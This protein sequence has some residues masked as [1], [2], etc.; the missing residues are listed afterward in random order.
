MSSKKLKAMHWFFPAVVAAMLSL[1]IA[2]IGLGRSELARAVE[3]AMHA[4]LFAVVAVVSLVWLRRVKPMESFARE[5]LRALTVAVALGA[6]GEIAQSMTASR[7]AE[8]SDLAYDILGAMA[9][10]CVFALFDTRRRLRTR[11][12]RTLVLVVAMSAVIVSIPV[13]EAGAYRWYSWRQLP[14]LATWHSRLG[15]HFVSAGGSVATV[16]FTPEP[17]SRQ[18]CDVS[19]HFSPDGP[20]RW[21]GLTIE[22]P[23]PDWRPYARLSVDIVNPNDAPLRLALRV[24]DW[25]HNND[26]RDRYNGTFEV[27]PRE[28]TTISVPTAAIATAPASRPMDMANISRVVMFQDAE[29]GARAF[30]L[31]SVRLGR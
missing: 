20:D 18:G 9:G 25:R 30:Y 3:D 28:R 13:V 15:H 6:L 29:R 14:E 11:V 5:Y 19:M 26:Y 24:N 8:W 23:T 31:C 4:P 10:L 12:R 16:V 1:L 27:G 17:W 2:P 7:H 22:E 21:P